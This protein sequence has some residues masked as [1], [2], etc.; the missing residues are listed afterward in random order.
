M[1]IWY[2]DNRMD[3]FQIMDNDV[4][5]NADC[6][7]VICN[8]N[9]LMAEKK[10]GSTL[11]VKNFGKTFNLYKSEPFSD[12]PTLA[13]R[14]GAGFLLKEDVIVTAGHL[15]DESNLEDTRFV[16]G[17]KM[18]NSSTA[19]TQIS[20]ENIYRGVEVLQRVYNPGTIGADWALAKLDRKVVGHPLARFSE[21][22]VS[23][24][25]PVY[26]IGHPCGLPLKYASGAKVRKIY[27]THFSAHL[28]VYFG[29]SGSPVFN[30]E[31]HEVVGIVVRGDTR[32]FRW[33][34]KGWVSIVY[35]KP[36]LLSRVPQ[37]T[38]ISEIIYDFLPKVKFTN[39]RFTGFTQNIINYL[40]GN[41][42]KKLDRDYQFLELKEI[43][44]IAPL[45]SNFNSLYIHALI[46]YSLYASKLM[47]RLLTFEEVVKVYE[48]HTKNRICSALNTMQIKHGPIMK[49]EAHKKEHL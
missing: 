20:D 38:K 28:S 1:G 10:G 26:I 17:Y 43:L 2:E 33:T 14:M 19:V 15:I 45:E 9:N 18:L 4:K 12:Q 40:K 48:S 42:P 24:E 8:K 30:T 7:A 39:V 37:C 47:I 32:D 22:D 5:R 23:L 3:Y 11:K 16:F 31:T 34:G 6:V 35:P 41:I 36:G 13:G 49:E 27:D 21:V 25:Q 29:N 46:K 44:K